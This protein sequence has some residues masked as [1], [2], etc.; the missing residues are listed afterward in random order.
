[1]TGYPTKTY[2]WGVN[3]GDEAVCY[4]DDFIMMNDGPINA[5]IGGQEI[6]AAYSPEYE[7][8]G[9]WYNH[10]SMPVTHIDFYGNSDQGELK[11]VETLKSGMF[12]HVWVEFFQHT[13][14]NRVG[15]PSDKLI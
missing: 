10:S 13:D 9:V 4:T 3:I 5:T 6:V 12:W 1:M 14:I 11:R 7:S 8:I 2:V 15:Q